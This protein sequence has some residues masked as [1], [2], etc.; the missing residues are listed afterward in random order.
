MDQAANSCPECSGQLQLV[1]SPSSNF[2]TPTYPPQRLP[3]SQPGAA[4]YRDG[5][6]T[7]LEGVVR[8]VKPNGALLLKRADDSVVVWH[9][10]DKS[11]SREGARSSPSP[12]LEERAGERRSSLE[13][14]I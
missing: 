9:A 1:T 6:W 2:P 13:P 8:T 4:R 10:D 14:L 5:Q 7:E 3:A 11:S 12:P